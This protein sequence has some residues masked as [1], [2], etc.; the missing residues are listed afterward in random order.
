[1]N[2]EARIHGNESVIQLLKQILPY[3][4]NKKEVAESILAEL[5][6]P[7]SPS[8]EGEGRGAVDT[9]V[10][11]PSQ[12]VSVVDTGVSSSGKVECKVEDVNK[13]ST[14]ESAVQ[15]TSQQ[16]DTTQSKQTSVNPA[17]EAAR[18]ILTAI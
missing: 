3:L 1:M 12:D 17:S 10:S 18:M 4:K 2:Y 16:T 7:A 13:P 6:S 8:A 14:V 11:E 5:T 9:G 15:P